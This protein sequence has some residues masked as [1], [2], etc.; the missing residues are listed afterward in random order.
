MVLGGQPISAIDI[1][2]PF[3]VAANADSAN[4]TASFVDM[5]GCTIDIATIGASAK[6][7]VTATVQYTVTAFTSSAVA[8]TQL[9][10]DGA[11]QPGSVVLVPTAN[12]FQVTAGQSWLVT[13]SPGTHTLKLQSR[14]SVPA[15]MTVIT[16][17]TSS[18]L[19]GVVFD[20]SL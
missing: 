19:S 8:T 17:A 2:A 20:S 15:N 10:V 13:V 7:W 14:N 4:L 18:N 11:A 12:S 9:L 16:R 6:I 1:P 5:P 3:A